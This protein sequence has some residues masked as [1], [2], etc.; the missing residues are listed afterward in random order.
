MTCDFTARFL[1]WVSV[2]G[3]SLFVVTFRPIS[4][5]RG[6]LATQLC[7][8]RVDDCPPSGP[9]IACH[10]ANFPYHC[11]V[12]GCSP[13]RRRIPMRRPIFHWCKPFDRPRPACRLSTVRCTIYARLRPTR[14]AL[15]RV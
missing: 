12:A 8:D 4:Y 5:S 15:G 1:G 13:S 9:C 7:H 2:T 14:V 3:I 6:L 10:P 11:R